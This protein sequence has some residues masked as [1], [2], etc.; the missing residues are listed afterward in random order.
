[1]WTYLKRKNS[2]QSSKIADFS[3]KEDI[4]DPSTL[5]SC[6]TKA[7]RSCNHEKT[8]VKCKGVTFNPFISESTFELWRRHLLSN[9]TKTCMCSLTTSRCLADIKFDQ[10][11]D[12]RL[13]FSQHCEWTINFRKSQF[14]KNVIDSLSKII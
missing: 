9:R 6:V 10:A 4:R 11:F 1:M 3:E 7:V 14:V 2:Q 13:A 12:G 5:T 8:V